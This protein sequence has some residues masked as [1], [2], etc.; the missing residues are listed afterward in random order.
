MDRL[1]L[2]K[3]YIDY[4]L[5][6][7]KDKQPPLE[8]YL[9]YLHTKQIK[10]EE[11]LIDHHKDIEK[12]NKNIKKLRREN[13]KLKIMLEYQPGGIGYQMAQKHFEDLREK[14]ENMK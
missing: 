9:K 4:Q 1:N 12:L 13:K 8:G 2:E 3:S 14:S 11:L 5:E 10:I 6:S 7:Y